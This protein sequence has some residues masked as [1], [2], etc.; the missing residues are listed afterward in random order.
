MMS[1]MLVNFLLIFCASASN[2]THEAMVATPNPT[3][4]P[5][6]TPNCHPYKTQQE[7]EDGSCTWWQPIKWKPSTTGECHIP[8][9]MY[10]EGWGQEK[11][12]NGTYK[13]QRMSWQK[14]C[15]SWPHCAM[16]KGSC[17]PVQQTLTYPYFFGVA[18]TSGG[19]LLIIFSFCAL[20]RWR[21][22]PAELA[23]MRA[24]F[25]VGFTIQFWVLW[26]GVPVHMHPQFYTVLIMISLWGAQLYHIATSVVLL[27]NIRNPF[28][29]EDYGMKFYHGIVWAV[30]IAVGCSTVPAGAAGYRW[31]LQICWIT[32]N[33]QFDENPISYTKEMLY[34]YLPTVTS[35]VLAIYVTCVASARLRHGL[36]D[37]LK[38]RQHLLKEAS[39]Q[40]VIV[41][42]FYYALWLFFYTLMLVDVARHP[43]ESKITHDHEPDPGTN[44]TYKVMFAIVLSMVGFVDAAVWIMRL[45]YNNEYLEGPDCR[46][47][48]NSALRK[49]V[50]E[51]TMHGIFECAELANQEPY[52]ATLPSD[53]MYPMVIE[54]NDDPT[55]TTTVNEVETRPPSQAASAEYYPTFIRDYA[56]QVFRY[57]RREVCGIEHEDYA[58]SIFTPELSQSMATE[59]YSEGR[60]GAFMY[61]THD[62][63]FI[64]KQIPTK[65]A[66]CLVEMLRDYVT[67]LSKHRNSLLCKFVG[68]HSLRI[69]NLTLYFVV[70]MNIFPTKPHEKYD[71]KGSWVNRHTNYRITDG[72]TMKDLDLH[73]RKIILDSEGTTNLKMQLKED[74]QFLKSHGIMDYSMLL[75][76]VYVKVISACNVAD[77]R[78]AAER[79]MTNAWST[80]STTAEPEPFSTDASNFLSPL[81]RRHANLRPIN[82]I[83]RLRD[84]IIRIST[85]MESIY[86]EY[87]GD[88][89]D[90]QGDDDLLDE[91]SQTAIQE[92]TELRQ[93]YE[94]FL[95]LLDTQTSGDIMGD[96]DDEFPAMRRDMSMGRSVFNPSTNQFQSFL[97]PSTSGGPNNKLFANGVKARVTEGPGVYYVGILDILT[98]WNWGKR[99]ERLSK[100]IFLRQDPPGISAIEPIQYEARFH[101]AMD[102]LI[103]DDETY[104]GKDEDVNLVAQQLQSL[105]ST[106]V[107]P[108]QLLNKANENQ[109]LTCEVSPLCSHPH[110]TT[111]LKIPNTHSRDRPSRRRD[112]CGSHLVN[113]TPPVP[114]DVEEPKSA[115]TPGKVP[116]K[117][118]VFSGL[119]GKSATKSFSGGFRVPLL[120]SINRGNSN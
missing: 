67:H 115:T 68:L 92:L 88:N 30:A 1:R 111:P 31:D 2:N 116:I 53:V 84:E 45:C 81:A 82:G 18:L 62:K 71:I 35:I 56:P 16:W 90:A 29:A 57:V 58:S 112:G 24:V 23:F 98:K 37:T 3:M 55:L 66:E 7:C 10:N 72:K 95:E 38:F 14:Q 80:M 94:G 4:Y 54:M 119:R 77:V 28:R 21:R 36:N 13:H 47:T 39:A 52:A 27:K 114:F 44:T 104:F 6:W 76:V 70:Q 103:V 50:L 64:I 101:E 74:T 48:V 89:I 79:R 93:Q 49:E 5:T 40:R 42:A 12:P 41:L 102:N 22:H 9:K 59:S 100:M 69:Y 106:T 109:T 60:S 78:G 63:R 108:R 19:A 96:F 25:D 83:A 32:N 86:A 75:G 33:K 85:T 15:N 43:L 87:G 34:I 61:H 26:A 107:W 65:E 110:T 120:H 46:Q 17:E 105:N 99:R 73:G 117:R 51:H 20:K 11:F 97:G 91:E 8:C 113:F 118:R